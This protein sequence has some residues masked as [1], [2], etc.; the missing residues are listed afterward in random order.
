LDFVEIA[1]D[2]GTNVSNITVT[3]YNSN[4]SIRSVNALETYVST[5]AG[6][7]VYIISTASSSTFNGLNK[8][9]AVALSDNGTVVQFISFD[10]GAPV[11]ATEG[12]TL[13]PTFTISD[14]KQNT[15]TGILTVD[16][17]IHNQD[18]ILVVDGHQSYLMRL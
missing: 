14:L 16:I 17:S 15:T 11:T 13:Y 2:E 18:G 10:D 8:A 9:G 4:G 1:V 12:D 5:N 6:R 7:D 3:I